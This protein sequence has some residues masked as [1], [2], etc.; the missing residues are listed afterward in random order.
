M[1]IRIFFISAILSL[2]F[3]SFACN[4]QAQTEEPREVQTDKS[5]EKQKPIDNAQDNLQTAADFA[6]KNSKGETIRLS[7]FEDK[8]IILNFWA[9]WCGP[10]RREIPGF[11]DLYRKYNEEGL[12]IIGVSVDQNGWEA[13][14]PFVE[15]YKVNYPILMF[16]HKVIGDYGGIRGIPTTF[17]IDRK[18]KIVEKIVGL[19]PDSY[20]EKRVKELL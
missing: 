4:D 2:S 13:V 5:E 8:V 20:F 12:E 10:C 14:K 1:M 17:I 7:S 16:N 6:L 18:G 11:V 15:N 3:L 9:T 19:R